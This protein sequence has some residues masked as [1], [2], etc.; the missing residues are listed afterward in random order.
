MS[1]RE[2]L[3]PERE[4]IGKPDNDSPLVVSQDD[5]Q[6]LMYEQ[7]SPFPTEDEREHNYLL[8]NSCWHS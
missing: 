8:K 4:V 5:A 7:H 1:D 2:Q 3:R 6:R